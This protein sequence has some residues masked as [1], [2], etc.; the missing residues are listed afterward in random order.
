VLA[1][2]EPERQLAGLPVADAQQRI[3]VDSNDR[4]RVLRRDCLDL[5]AAGTLAALARCFLLWYETWRD[6][7]FA[8]VR[9][10]WLERATGLGDQITV[11]LDRENVAGRFLGID[12]DGAL[13][14][15]TVDG[16]RRIAAGDVFPANR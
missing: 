11:R 12:A 13:A 16:A 3:D 10:A 6:E 2:P 1:E 15:E 8:S 4:V 5:D 9:A 14:L 7:G